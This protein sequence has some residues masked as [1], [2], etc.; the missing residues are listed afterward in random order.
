MDNKSGDGSRASQGYRRRRVAGGRTRGV[1]VPMSEEEYAEVT[2][3]AGLL[4]MAVSAYVGQAAVAAARGVSPPQW[5]P[6]RDL[7]RL[8]VYATSQVRRAGI[9]LNQ[10]VAALHTTGQPTGA[11]QEQADAAHRSVRQLDQLAEHIRRFI[12]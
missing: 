4:K 10:A 1:R 9:N 2:G 7:M 11:L 5:S 6:L 3:A 12:T 8:L